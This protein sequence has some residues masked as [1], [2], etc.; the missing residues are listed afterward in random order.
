MGAHRTHRELVEGSM[1]YEYNAKVVRWIDGDTV[2]LTVDLGFHLTKT[3]HFRLDGIDT[4]ER[5]K[6]GYKEATARAMSLAPVGT[7]VHT[8]TSKA[9]KYGRYLAVLWPDVGPPINTVLVEEGLA[10][11]YW[12]G[13]K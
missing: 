11:P 10:T 8:V 7:E 2:E 12:G 13:T 5:G 1:T 6:P 3:D 9:D 4:P